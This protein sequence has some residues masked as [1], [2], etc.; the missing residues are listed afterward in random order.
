MKRK[1]KSALSFLLLLVLISSIFTIPTSA[2]PTGINIKFYPP[3]NWG[4]NIKIYLWNAG[5]Q[6]NSWP[7]ISM[8][9][10]ND[11]SYSYQ[12]N[13]IS[14]CNFIVNNGSGQQSPNLYT[15]GWVGVASDF[16]LFEISDSTA[17]INF[18]RPSNWGTNIYMY[19]YDATT[20]AA[21]TSWPGI[22]MTRQSST[23][24]YN[25]YIRDMS[26]VRVLF[27]DNSGNQY[28]ASGQP[29]IPVKAGEALAFQDGK[30][31]T[32]QYSWINVTQPTTFAVENQ[33]YHVK[34][35]LSYGNNFSLSF[36]DSTTWA[37]VTPKSY[38]VTY[39]NSVYQYDYIFEFDTIGTQEIDVMYYYHSST[40]YSGETFTVN[41]GS[42]T[43][44][45]G[46]YVSSDKL[47]VTLG[48]TFT[49]TT[50]NLSSFKISQ[51][52]WDDAGNQLTPI[53][54]YYSYAPGTSYPE[55]RHFVFAANSLG[56]GQYQKIHQSHHHAYSP[57]PIDTGAFVT[58]N[59]WAN[60]N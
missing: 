54:T 50:S 14:S 28:P 25:G 46:S 35:D 59:V 49:I 3:S 30:Y 13:A 11:G 37:P 47:D 26:N 19:Y 9:A 2:A 15:N 22:L 6:N 5:S 34:I 51:T 32:S 56:L 40:G 21:L 17:Y 36:R 12:T 57:T 41:V 60:A 44:S 4:S 24:F 43:I 58:I 7:G 1:F 38:T 20:Q 31:T 39:N 52:F 29:G 27:T 53:S 18:K 33:D 23:D 45:H 48:D 55:Y 16:T 10:N 8:T 42:S